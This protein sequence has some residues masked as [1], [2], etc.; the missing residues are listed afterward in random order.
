MKLLG[1]IKMCLNESCKVRICKHLSG[2]FPIQNYLKQ[3]D[4]S[5]PLF[6]NFASEYVIRKVQKNPGGTEIE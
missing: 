5:L 6:S 2:S 4:A 3:G 1:L